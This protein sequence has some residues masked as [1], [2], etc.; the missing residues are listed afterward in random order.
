MSSSWPSA[1]TPMPEHLARQQVA[2]AERAQQQLDDA[3]GLLLDDPG[4]GPV[5]VAD[6]LEEQ[7]EHRDQREALRLV[8]AV[9]VEPMT[10]SG[11]ELSAARRARLVEPLACERGIGAQRR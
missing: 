1:T 10:R 4:R 6:E 5:A 3:R 7:Q 11:G 2:R 8:V 9:L